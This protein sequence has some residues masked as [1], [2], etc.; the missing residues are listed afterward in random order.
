[1][2]DLA[3]VLDL[4]GAGYRLDL[5]E[6]AYIEGLVELTVPMLDRGLGVAVYTYETQGARRATIR[7]LGFSSRF[8][9]AW[10][11]AFDATVEAAALQ[12]PTT[13]CGFER[14]AHLPCAQVSAVPGMG[15]FLPHFAVFGG[16]QDVFAINALDVSGRGLWL[17]APWPEVSPA[18]PERDTL[19]TRVAAH[20]TSAH[21]LR[22]MEQRTSE[23]VLSPDGTLLHAEE[24]AKDAETRAELRR[25]AMALEHARSR[26]GRQDV[27]GSTRRWRPLVLS[28]WSLL[29]EFDTDG[30]RFVVAV[31]NR[32][33]ARSA[34]GELS[35]REHQVMSHAK[36]GHSNKVIAYELGLSASTVRVLMHRAVKKLGAKSRGEALARFDALAAEPVPRD[37]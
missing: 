7:E 24:P 14:W 20:L 11:Q 31:N 17:G 27:E 9:P 23:A 16:A 35:E 12:D 18:S 8:D 34:R 28:R 37:A 15:P 33:S 29:D 6:R 19:F 22:R 36:L 4:L 10:L 26:A 32:A 25:A 2:Q 13:I 1:M 30:R 3:L 5:D 21:R